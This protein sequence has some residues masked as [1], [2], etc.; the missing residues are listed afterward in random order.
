MADCRG[1]SRG[2]FQKKDE[3]EMAVGVRQKVDLA[4]SGAVYGIFPTYGILWY[5]LYLQET[6]GPPLP[7]KIFSQPERYVLYVQSTLPTSTSTLR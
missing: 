7:R 5:K 4:H 2:A 6:Y 3:P 1:V